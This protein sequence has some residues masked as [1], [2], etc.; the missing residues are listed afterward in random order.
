MDRFKWIDIMMYY[1][2]YHTA[3]L[4]KDNVLIAGGESDNIISD[5][6]E[7]YN[8]ENKTFTKIDSMNE[9][10]VLHTALNLLNGMILIVGGLC[11]SH[12]VLD[13]A[14]LYD[15]TNNKFIKINCMNYP[16]S[17]HTATLLDG[18]SVL[19]TGGASSR[20]ARN[21]LNSAEI[22]CIDT[23]CFIQINSMNYQRD[24]HTATL[25]EKNNMK[26]VLIAGGRSGL[27]NNNDEIILNKAEIYCV[28]TKQFTKINSM[29][30]SRMCHTATNLLN[31]YI[32]ITGGKDYGETISN[33]AEL[34]CIE[35]GEFIETSNLIYE[36]DFHTATNLMN[37][38]VLITGG[39]DS[40][41][42]YLNC[43]EMYDIYTNEFY[44]VDDMIECRL[45]PIV[46]NL[47]NMTLLITGGSN[48]R[49]KT[50]MEMGLNS[51]E[52]YII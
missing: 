37:G 20:S 23:N 45:Y 11:N 9:S 17:I 19:I 47:N 40:N 4:F 50:D 49:N 52:L 24:C 46:T 51:A 30:H 10:R 38:G 44:R 48:K 7:L 36:R 41:D 13:S 8:I 14:E 27:Y 3:T 42:N 34:Y 33:S 22:Y 16:R 29:K 25:F 18:K 43:C 12:I 6:A 28:E 39:R 21:I 31:G 5:S 32:L 2:V 35:T 15:T 26:Y 1:R